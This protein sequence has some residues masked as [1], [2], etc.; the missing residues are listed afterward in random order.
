MKSERNLNNKTYRPH[1]MKLHLEAA[2]TDETRRF[3]GGK[4]LSRTL[5]C[6]DNFSPRKTSG[7]LFLLS[8][9]VQFHSVRSIYGS[10]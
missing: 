7:S 3:A 5:R 6:G 1:T 4:K 8:Y 10:L 9:G 2:K